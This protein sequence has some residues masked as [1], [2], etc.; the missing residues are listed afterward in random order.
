MLYRDDAFAIVHGLTDTFTIATTLAKEP[1]GAAAPDPPRQP[2][3]SN[4]SNDAVAC[5]SPNLGTAVPPLAV[6]MAALSCP[7]QGVNARDMGERKRRRSSSGYGR[8]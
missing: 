5:V 7:R 6:V 8:A 4:D 2:W 3:R 1:T